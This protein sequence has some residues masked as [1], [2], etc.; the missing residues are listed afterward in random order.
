MKTKN[1]FLLIVLFGAIVFYSCSKKEGC[2]D[3]SAENYDPNAEKD[4][5]TCIY[6]TPTPPVATSG[7]VT[8]TFA[9]HFAGTTV[10]DHNLHAPSFSYVNANNDTLSISKL[11]YLISDI[12]FY[13]SNGDSLVIE[14]HHFVD[15]TNSVTLTYSPTFQ[16]PFDSYTGV[17]FNFGLDSVDNVSQAHIDL[18]SLTW[19]W[20][21][22]MGGGYHFMQMEGHFMYQGNDSTYTYHM[23]TAYN[24]MTSTAEQNYFKTDLGAITITNNATIQ[25]KMDISEWYKN[26]GTWDLNQYHSGL[27][28]NYTAQKLM[29]TIGKDVFS[30]G[31]VVQ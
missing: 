25:I 5:G 2:T 17:S 18:N 10:I 15:L 6:K 16:L 1:L 8:F 22:D 12:R 31:V 28:G 9:H 7:S 27:M 19:N 26:P 13:K 14:G 29:N 20:P 21:D 11:K 23:G 30:L 3:P 4:N 24:M